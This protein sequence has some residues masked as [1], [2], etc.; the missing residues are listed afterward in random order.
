[1]SDMAAR[2]M[3]PG[4]HQSN[5]LYVGKMQSKS[6]N[7]FQIVPDFEKIAEAGDTELQVLTVAPASLVKKPASVMSISDDEEGGNVNGS[8]DSD[9]EEAG[10]QQPEMDEDD[11]SET[12]QP[13]RRAAD[14]HDRVNREDEDH[15]DDTASD[16]AEDVTMDDEDS[17]GAEDESHKDLFEK[18]WGKPAASRPSESDFDFDSEDVAKSNAETVTAS[19]HA[20][21]RELGLISGEVFSPTIQDQVVDIAILPK[22]S[23]SKQTS[24]EP[25]PFTK[26]RKLA[27][28]E[29]NDE[30]SREAKTSSTEM[31]SL[32]LQPCSSLSKYLRQHHVLHERIKHL[33]SHLPRVM[34]ASFAWP[35]RRYWISVLNLTQQGRGLGQAVTDIGPRHVSSINEKDLV[36]MQGN[37][38]TTVR[39]VWH[40]FQTRTMCDAERLVLFL[41]GVEAMEVWQEDDFASD[42][43]QRNDAGDVKVTE[44]DLFSD[45][46]VVFVAKLRDVHPKRRNLP[47]IRGRSDR[48]GRE[49]GSMAAAGES[50]SQC[51]E[52]V[53][54]NLLGELIQ[55][56]RVV[57]D[58]T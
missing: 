40:T 35:E 45:K 53:G 4:T 55:E 12:L 9:E 6:H 25:L 46:V 23:D 41:G 13:L 17:S 57:I 34:T 47:T 19:N 18:I 28:F 42:G 29:V 43:R 56:E 49:P 20:E 27:T 5:E 44:C 8:E 31:S 52:K 16:S 3:R 50:R 14:G 58:L 7:A 39:T 36:W 21:K 51:Y 15:D 2:L 1:M 48:A 10:T 38:S 37:R 54:A 22:Q 24:P 26:R 33:I 30:G 11:R 32:S